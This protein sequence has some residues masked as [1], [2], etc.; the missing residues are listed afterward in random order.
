MINFWF[1]RQHRRL[2]KRFQM[3]TLERHADQIVAALYAR[4]ADR[5]THNAAY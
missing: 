5:G 2:R 3:T 1:M 4:R